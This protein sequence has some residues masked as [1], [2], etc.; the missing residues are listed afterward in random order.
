MEPDTR[1]AREEISFS[2]RPHLPQNIHVCWRWQGGW[3]RVRRERE[4]GRFRGIVHRDKLYAHV[5]DLD[6]NRERFRDL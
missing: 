5:D 6:L 4:R 2:H 1:A 3:A